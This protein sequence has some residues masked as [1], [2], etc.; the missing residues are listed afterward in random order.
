MTKSTI[1][2]KTIRN[3]LA[4]LTKRLSDNRKLKWRSAKGM[5]KETTGT[6]QGNTKNPHMIKMKNKSEP[7]LPVINNNW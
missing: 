2:N 5:I 4:T 3:G 1:T 6:H 7:K